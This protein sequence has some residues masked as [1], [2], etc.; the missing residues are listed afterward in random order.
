MRLPA[1]TYVA[2]ASPSP[3]RSALPK[4]EACEPPAPGGIIGPTN[5]SCSSTAA[6]ASSQGLFLAHFRLNISHVFVEYDKAV[7]VNH[8]AHTAVTTH[9]CHEHTNLAINPES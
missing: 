9:S 4:L 6:A 8:T 1:C 3:G 7:I 5:S 2:M